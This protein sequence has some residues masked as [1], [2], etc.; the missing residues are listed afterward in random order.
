MMEWNEEASLVVPQYH[1][2]SKMNILW[3]SVLL[4]VSHFQKRMTSISLIIISKVIIIIVITNSFHIS[5]RTHNAAEKKNRKCLYIFSF[6]K[7][8]RKFR[9]LSMKGK[10][11]EKRKTTTEEKNFRENFHSFF[12]D[13]QT[14]SASFIVVVVVKFFFLFIFFP[15]AFNQHIA[16]RQ[17]I[18]AKA[19]GWNSKRFHEHVS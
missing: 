9:C 13:S 1:L 8:E 4:R 10:K 11:R 19:R 15:F 16:R 7:L 12:L 17:Q 14:A 2:H 3:A 18:F 6:K 5:S